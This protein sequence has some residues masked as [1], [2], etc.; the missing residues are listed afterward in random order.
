[1][2]PWRYVLASL[3]QHRSI[4]RAVAAG[5]ALTAMVITGA[6]LVGD[7]VRGSLLTLALRSLGRIDSLLIAEHP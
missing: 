7:S 6:L 1:M 3:R 2:T 4:Y 5:V